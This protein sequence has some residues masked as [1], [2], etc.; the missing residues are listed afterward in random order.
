MILVEDDIES[1]LAKIEN[2]VIILNYKCKLI[3]N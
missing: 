2:W 1:E 3:F